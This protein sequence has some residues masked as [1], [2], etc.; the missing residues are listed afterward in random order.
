M[1]IIAS[2]SMSNPGRSD[3]IVVW[4]ASVRVGIPAYTLFMTA[5]F[6]MSRK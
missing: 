1:A 3:W 6:A 4:P 5:K 2:T